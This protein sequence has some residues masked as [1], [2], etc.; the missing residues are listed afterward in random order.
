MRVKHDADV[1]EQDSQG[2]TAL[3]Y[4][5]VSGHVAMVLRLLKAGANIA[6][7]DMHNRTAQVRTGEIRVV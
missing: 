7:V 1:D 4:A 5:A 3:H 6:T 2:R